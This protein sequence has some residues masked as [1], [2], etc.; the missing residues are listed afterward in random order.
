MASRKVK[1]NIYIE[2]STLKA[3][4]EISARTMIPMASL[5]RKGIDQVIREYSKKN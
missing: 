1:T 2:Q 4:K 5:I 3:L